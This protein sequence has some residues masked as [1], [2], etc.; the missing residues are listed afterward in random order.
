MG[1]GEGEVGTKGGAEDGSKDCI[2]LL[3]RI[4]ISKSVV[5]HVCM[6]RDIV[7]RAFACDYTLVK[8][9]LGSLDGFK[10][11]RCLVGEKGEGGEIKFDY[12]LNIPRLYQHV[13]EIFFLQPDAD[14]LKF[15]QPEGDHPMFPSQTGLYKIV[16]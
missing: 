5:N 16:D 2:G 4:G 1:N 10:N 7:P 15:A 11:H 13:S 3:E 8:S 9:I 14:R 6:H 12:G